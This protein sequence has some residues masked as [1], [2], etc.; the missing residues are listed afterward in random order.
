MSP[1]LSVW[2]YNTIRLAKNLTLVYLNKKYES[3]SCTL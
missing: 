1:I 3:Q 2:E